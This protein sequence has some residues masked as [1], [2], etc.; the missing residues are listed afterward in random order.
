[1]TLKDKRNS[2]EYNHSLEEQKQMIQQD[3]EDKAMIAIL[4]LA[5]ICSVIVLVG[6]YIRVM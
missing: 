1:M 3:K 4:I 2:F 6:H 5:A